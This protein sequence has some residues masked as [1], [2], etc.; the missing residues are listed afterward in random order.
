MKETQSWNIKMAIVHHLN[1]GIID[2]SE[3]FTKV[4]EELKVPRPSV[5][6]CSR[7]LVQD[8]LDKINILASEF[9]PVKNN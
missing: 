9:D 4:V 2:K 3:I 1:K 6:R 7:E 8:M 5:R